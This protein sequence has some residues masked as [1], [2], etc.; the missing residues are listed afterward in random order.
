MSRLLNKHGIVI[1]DIV[2]LMV[3]RNV[4]YRLRIGNMMG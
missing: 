3:L 4:Q 2:T 1:A